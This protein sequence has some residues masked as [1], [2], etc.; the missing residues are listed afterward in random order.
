MKLSD[1][2]AILEQANLPVTYRAFKI[3]NDPDLPYL[4]YYESSPVINSADNT[5]NHQIKSVTV[6]LAFESKDEDLEE[7]LEE[8]WANHK[9]FFEVQEETFI[10]TER[11]YVKSYTVYLY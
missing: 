1:F 11:L 7:R 4:V 2:A 9:L 8:L 3:G 6:E 10:E 5:V